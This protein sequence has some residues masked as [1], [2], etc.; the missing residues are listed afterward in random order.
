MRI[1]PPRSNGTLD[2]NSAAQLADRF[3]AA[4]SSYVCRPHRSGR[5][6]APVFGINRR[7]TQCFIAETV[8]R[9]SY[10]VLGIGPRLSKAHRRSSMRAHDTPSVSR[11][12]QET[13][14][15]LGDVNE[16][17][18]LLPFATLAQLRDILRQRCFLN[19]AIPAQPL[20]GTRSFFRERCPW[21]SPAATGSRRLR[22]NSTGL[23]RGAL[24][25]AESRRN[26]PNRMRPGAGGHTTCG[27]GGRFV[28]G[29]GAG[30]RTADQAWCWFK[31]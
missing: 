2:Q 4:I 14:A 21:L 19:E 27:E 26:L 15:A 17:V 22:F 31:S 29:C 7:A 20:Q 3:H 13:I 5:S 1:R 16:P 30:E 25:S 9:F 6:T 18:F 10:I 28:S 24:L 8:A 11:Q 23:P 12:A